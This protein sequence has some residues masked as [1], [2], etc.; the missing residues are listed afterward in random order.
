LKL[1]YSESLNCKKL[2]CGVKPK[3]MVVKDALFTNFKIKDKFLKIERYRK[4]TLKFQEK[5]NI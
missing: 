3:F 2:G 1:E 4:Y 5:K